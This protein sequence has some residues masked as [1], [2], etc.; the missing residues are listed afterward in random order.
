MT[1]LLISQTVAERLNLKIHP[2]K[3]NISMALT[4][5]TTHVIGHCFAD[6]DLI[7]HVYTCTRL[8]VLKDL[9]SDIILGHDFQKEHERVTIE[10]GGN[11]P[12][13]ITPNS[14]PVCA[15]CAATI[16]EI[17]LFSNL[18]PNLSPLNPGV[19]ARMTRISFNKKFLSFSPVV[20]LRSVHR[21]DVH[22]WL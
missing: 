20:L 15:V 18:L 19:S 8:G 22:K 12:E 13:L 21:L 7:Q 1:P 10:F 6:I 2:S 11:K 17:Y 5:L 4:S 14:A 9:C 16:D 3:Q